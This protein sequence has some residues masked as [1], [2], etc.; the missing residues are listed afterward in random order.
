MYEIYLKK[1]RPYQAE[2]DNYKVRMY[3]TKDAVK[4]HK[5]KFEKRKKRRVPRVTIDEYSSSSCDD[6]KR[7]ISEELYAW[8][9][10]ELEKIQLDHYTLRREYLHLTCKKT[11]DHQDEKH[12]QC[13]YSIVRMPEPLLTL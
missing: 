6:N 9:K 10:D 4:A 3:D 8:D 7:D 11:D 5:H 13:E 2:I 12:L 1:K